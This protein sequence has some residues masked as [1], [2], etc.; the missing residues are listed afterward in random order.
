MFKYAVAHNGIDRLA[1]YCMDLAADTG[2]VPNPARVAARKAVKTAEAT[3][4]T[5]ERALPQLL[6]GTQT[7]KQM[8]AALPGVHRRIEKAT[9]ALEQA[10]TALRPIPAK[11][12]ATDLD[13]GALRARPRL[14][15]RGLQMVL[16]LLAFN[17]GAWLAEHFNAYLTD[18]NEYRAILRH[19]LHQGGQIHYTSTAITITLDRPDTPRV[20]RALTLP[21]QELNANPASLPGDRRPLTYQLTAAKIQPATQPLLAEV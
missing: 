13:P 17:A 2:K 3:L 6:A 20:A 15:R 1:D 8:N 19:L 7:P 12:A 10:K 16:R 14:E 9:S 5:A 11:V 18:P 21:T 4:I